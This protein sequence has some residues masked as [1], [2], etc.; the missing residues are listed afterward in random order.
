MRLCL[1]NNK[2]T[3]EPLNFESSNILQLP[4]EMKL[5]TPKLPN[6]KFAF[7][8]L[9]RFKSIDMR[10]LLKMMVLSCLLGVTVTSQAQRFEAGLVAGINLSQIDGD[11]LAGFNKPGF[12]AGAKVATILSD[13]WQLSLEFLFSQQGASRSK[14]DDPS[15]AYD[16]IRLNFVEVPVMINFKEWKFHLSGGV[17]YARLID[18]QVIDALGGDAT[19]SQEFNESMFSLVFGGTYYF[20]EN[21]G[22]E[23]RWFRALQDLQKQQGAS[24]LIGRSISFR[25]I[26][27]L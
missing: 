16:K 17:S 4:Q 14:Y 3:F 19:D 9:Q 10:I 22:F 21:M 27:L 13:R 18:Y 5:S 2:F 25:L 7:L 15:S 1:Q 26:Y 23:V 6:Y 8:F 24:S 11:R 12:N 20:R